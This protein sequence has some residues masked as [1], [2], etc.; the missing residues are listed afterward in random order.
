MFAGANEIDEI[1]KIIPFLHCLK[2][3]QLYVYNYEKN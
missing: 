1:L 3:N 2:S